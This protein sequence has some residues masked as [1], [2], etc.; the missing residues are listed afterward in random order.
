MDLHDL[1]PGEILERGIEKAIENCEIFFAVLSTNSIRRGKFQ[2]LLKR[3]LQKHNSL[4]PDDI[5]IIPVKI[6]NCETPEL[7]SEFQIT[8]WYDE[9]E[10]RKN[11]G[12]LYVTGVKNKFLN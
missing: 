11:P 3:A 8:K 4:L 7:L 10:K 9:R 2:I 6:D 1:K 12:N 5:Y